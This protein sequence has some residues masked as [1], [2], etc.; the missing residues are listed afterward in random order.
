MKGF[1]YYHNILIKKYNKKVLNYKLKRLTN[2]KSKS[3]LKKFL[4]TKYSYIKK[5]NQ[6]LKD[7]PKNLFKN[8]LNELGLFFNMN[9]L[10]KLFQVL[11]LVIKTKK[12]VLFFYDL[13]IYPITQKRYYINKLNQLFSIFPGI[14]IMTLYRPGFLSN[15]HLDDFVF[16]IASPVIIVFLNYNSLVKLHK[17]FLHEIIK[18]YYEYILITKSRDIDLMYKK[19]LLVVPLDLTLGYHFDFFYLS[20][21]NFLIEQEKFSL[22]K[23]TNMFLIGDFIYITS[24]NLIYF[25][26]IL[27]SKFLLKYI[28]K[29][30]KIKKKNKSLSIKDIK[31]IIKTPTKYR[32]CI[33]NLLSIQM[34]Y[35]IERD[36][37]KYRQICLSLSQKRLKKSIIPV[38]FSPRKLPEYIIDKKNLKSKINKKYKN[39]DKIKILQNKKDQ[40]KSI[41]I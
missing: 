16:K 40:T 10:K 8:K 30:L 6:Y 3:F 32:T 33:K 15:S 23:K 38:L 5:R 18:Y 1:T 35:E 14:K 11:T 27:Q 34:T 31:L 39:Y 22:H 19:P 2:K 4:T 37:L 36:Y 17:I 12:T 9:S 41:N 29:K 20:L 26:K 21:V 28:K 7:N 25:I 13:T 24:V